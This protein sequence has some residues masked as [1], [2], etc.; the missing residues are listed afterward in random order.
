MFK[1]LPSLIRLNKKSS[2]AERESE[3]ALNEAI[4]YPRNKLT[5]REK[6]S[7]C[8]YRTY[9]YFLEDFYISIFLI[10]CRYSG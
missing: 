1:L 8:S 7:I 9:L 10:K 2:L 4:L 6:N 3:R 5:E